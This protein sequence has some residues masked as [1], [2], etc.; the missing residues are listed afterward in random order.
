MKLQSYLVAFAAALSSVH[1]FKGMNFGAQMPSGACKSEADW[2]KNFQIMHSLPGGFSSARVFASSDCNTLAN[3]VPAA[4]ATNTKILVGVWN[5][6]LTHFNAE[7]QALLTAIQQH[8]HGWIAAVSVGSEDLYRG[9]TDAAT[10]SKHIHDVRGMISSVGAS[11]IQVGHVDTWTAWVNP[12]NQAVIDACDFIGMDGYPYFQSSGIGNAASVF[13]ESVTRTRNA[14]HAK[15][16]NKKVWITET[17]WPSSGPSEGHAV[18]S[19]ANLQTYYKEVGCALFK[20]EINT[21][22]YMFRDT[23]ASPSFGVVDA[24]FHPIIDLNC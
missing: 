20:D 11:S 24:N 16:P 18:P 7:K 19:V 1:A 15:Y 8:G 10:L 2:L 21:F 17:G 5:E 23:G 12:A 13:W 4:L 14:V 9:N 3:A 6:D 22:W